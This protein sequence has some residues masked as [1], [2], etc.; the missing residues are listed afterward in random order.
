MFYL[1]DCIIKII[2]DLVETNYYYP[3]N[4]E[5]RRTLNMNTIYGEV[6]QIVRQFVEFVGNMDTSISITENPK[7]NNK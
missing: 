7:H 6:M 3:K 4:D 2:N 5:P 1:L